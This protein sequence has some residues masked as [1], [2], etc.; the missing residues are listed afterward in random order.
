LLGA[1]SRFHE[2]VED[3]SRRVLG[4]LAVHLPLLVPAAIG[5]LEGK[6]TVDL[7]ID[8][9]AEL[10]PSH[11]AQAKDEVDAVL[12]LLDSLLRFTRGEDRSKAVGGMRVGLVRRPPV[13][14]PQHLPVTPGEAE[15][16]VG[17]NDPVLLIG[18]EG[19]PVAPRGAKER[20]KAKKDVGFPATHLS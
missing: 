3:L 10:I 16:A 1:P 2:R 18:R 6:K 15:L 5:A 12:K 17:G 20:P 13:A 8:P 11:H 14:F 19:V 7:G 9:S 4:A